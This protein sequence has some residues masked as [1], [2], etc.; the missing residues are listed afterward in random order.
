MTEVSRLLTSK[1]SLRVKKVSISVSHIG[2]NCD[3]AWGGGNSQ[4]A[5]RY[6]G[7][8]LRH[9]LLLHTFKLEK[10]W[11]KHSEHAHPDHMNLIDVLC[12]FLK[13]SHFQCLALVDNCLPL[14]YIQ[15]LVRAFLLSS[16]SQPQ[17]LRLEK[18]LLTSRLR[19]RYLSGQYPSIYEKE[20]KL[21]LTE[22][23][24]RRSQGSHSVISKTAREFK[25][26]TI[27]FHSGGE[28]H[29]DKEDLAT[30]E[31]AR[32]WLSDLSRFKCELK[33]FIVQ[34]DPCV[35]NRHLW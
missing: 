31:A 20:V 12:S 17:T 25:T 8:M 9:L 18:L 2:K 26:L 6:L 13:Q 5:S 11:T 21:P 27:A 35:A 16:C 24:T 4:D 30:L 32:S 33:S 7:S 23:D 14:V 28:G 19:I 10:W 1:Y 3:S 29:P 15:R 34:G 22:W